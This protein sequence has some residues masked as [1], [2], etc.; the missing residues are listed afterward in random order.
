MF[1]F[2]NIIKYFYK[3]I[4]LLTHSERSFD[5]PVTLRHWSCHSS[6][7]GSGPSREERSMM[8][9]VLLVLVVLDCISVGKLNHQ[10]LSGNFIS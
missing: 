4:F 10:Q 1:L 5:H 8:W 6:L 2:H 9:V 7:V 3:Y